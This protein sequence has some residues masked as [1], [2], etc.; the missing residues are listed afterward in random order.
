M[1]RQAQALLLSPLLLQL[2]GGEDVDKSFGS[3]GKASNPWFQSP[4]VLKSAP[5]LSAF[6]RTQLHQTIGADYI[7]GATSEIAN[8]FEKK[9]EQLVAVW[10][11]AHRS[12]LTIRSCEPIGTQI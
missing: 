10:L 2:G 3:R 5:Q 9:R 1:Y 11:S 8:L 12:S 7:P 4:T 6:E